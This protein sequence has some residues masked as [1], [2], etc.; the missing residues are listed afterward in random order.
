M[1]AQCYFRYECVLSQEV[2]IDEHSSNFQHMYTSFMFKE[3]TILLCFIIS[4][5]FIYLFCYYFSTFSFL[6]FFFFSIWTVGGEHSF[7]LRAWSGLSQITRWVRRRQ[8]DGGCRRKDTQPAFRMRAGLWFCVR[9]E[10]FR[11]SFV[12]YLVLLFVIFQCISSWLMR[13]NSWKQGKRKR[14]HLE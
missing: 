2:T 14:A 6:V 4:F 10:D 7:R 12:S 11:L 3:P 13:D 9:I 5:L 1:K 8:D